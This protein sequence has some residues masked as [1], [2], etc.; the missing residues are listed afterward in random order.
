[1]CGL[2]LMGGPVVLLP[3][4][5]RADRQSPCGYDSTQ[6]QGEEAAVWVIEFD[7]DRPGR[8]EGSTNV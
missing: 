3:A 8:K 2:G 5:W 1:L 6:K 7:S 4:T